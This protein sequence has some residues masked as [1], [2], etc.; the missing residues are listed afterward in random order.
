MDF[1]RLFHPSFLFLLKF[2]HEKLCKKRTTKPLLFSKRPSRLRLKRITFQFFGASAVFWP[3]Y[4]RS[5]TMFP[6]PAVFWFL[7]ARPLCKGIRRYIRT[8]N[9]NIWHYAWFETVCESFKQ[10][11]VERKCSYSQLMGLG[12]ARFL[13]CVTP[14]P[15]HLSPKV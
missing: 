2:S 9:R 12:K 8:R 15:G 10:R 14:P 11:G 6:A 1:D 13:G 7:A 4:C 3:D 5:L